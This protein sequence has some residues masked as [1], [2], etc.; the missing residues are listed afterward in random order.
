MLIPGRGRGEVLQLEITLRQLRRI[1]T[2]AAIAIAIGSSGALVGALSAPRAGAYGDLLEENLTLKGHL[3][4]IEIQLDEVEVTLRRIQLYDAQLRDIYE[5][6]GLGG[7]GPDEALPLTPAP[8]PWLGAEGDPM[9]EL[10]DEPLVSEDLRP[11]EVWALAVET[12][13]TTVL[14]LLQRVEPE[15]NGLSEDAADLLSIRSAFPQIWPLQGILTSGF[16]YRRSPI[17]RRWKFHSGIDISAP[18]GTR[19]YA[20]APGRVTT[21]E[22]NGGYGRMVVIDHGYGVET[23]YAH[24]ASL[25]VRAGD[26][27]E[28]G[29]VI[30]T[31]GNTGQSTGPHLHFEL[32]INGQKVDP[33]D[34]LPR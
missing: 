28:A 1:G 21:A 3:Q 15:I 25:F 27:V 24:N 2:I 34:Y 11:A 8:D 5:E 22:Y 17:G 20:A 29:Q 7:R 13:A 23:R 31:V 6:A 19:I 30:T 32:A 10:I 18:R 12:R 26:W 16:G 9:E 14:H 33:L 4:D